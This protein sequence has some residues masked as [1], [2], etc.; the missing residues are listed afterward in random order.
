LGAGTDKRIS[1]GDMGAGESRQG[2]RPD[3]L[4]QDPDAEEEVI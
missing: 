4:H 3:Q 1:E 2:T